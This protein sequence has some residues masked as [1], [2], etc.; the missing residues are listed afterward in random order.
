MA[1]NNVSKPVT[2]LHR[3]VSLQRKA[4]ERK[5]TIMQSPMK[6]AVAG[7]TGRVGRYVVNTLEA[8]GHYVVAMSRSSGVDVISR[9][10]LDEAM[11][12]VDTIIDVA[13]GPVAGPGYGHR[14]FHHRGPELA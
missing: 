5:R 12:G 2:L 11:E 7:A 6:I 14:V 9:Q 13:T 3:D 8:G 1:T 4:N 10:G